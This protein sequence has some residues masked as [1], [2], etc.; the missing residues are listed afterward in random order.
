MKSAS[1]F[2]FPKKDPTVSCDSS[3]GIWKIIGCNTIVK[4][5]IRTWGS[6]GELVVIGLT[7][8]NQYARTLHGYKGLSLRGETLQ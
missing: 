7:Q 1:N 8:S 2:S 5:V 4:H 3:H 6:E